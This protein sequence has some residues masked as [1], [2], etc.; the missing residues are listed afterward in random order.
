[1]PA[2][3]PYRDRRGVPVTSDKTSLGDRMKSH[4]RVTRA[5]LP[6]RTYSIL[7]IDGRCFS[8]YLRHANKP[9]DDAVVAAMNAVAEALCSGISG[10]AFAYTQSDE[11]SVLIT[12]FGSEHT[13]PWFGGNIQ[14]IASVAASI[15]TVAFNDAYGRPFGQ[16]RAVF[17]ARTFTLPNAVEVANY[18]LWRQRDCVRNSISMAAQAVFPHK[19]L[20]KVNSDQ[21]QELLWLEHGIN[22]NDYPPGCK[23]GRV[24]V[25]QVGEQ[26]I[27]YTDKRTQLP[28]TT[29]AVRSWWETQ[30]APHFTAEP[31]RWLAAT[32]PAAASFEPPPASR[33]RPVVEV[34]PGLRFGRPAIEG[35]SCN[36]LSERV[37]AGEDPRDVADDYDFTRAQILVACWY[38]AEHQTEPWSAGWKTWAQQAYRH[39]VS[40]DHDKI[41]DPPSKEDT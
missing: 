16:T 14:K 18:M 23:R 13:Q 15:A 3:R 6:P 34:Q 31:G 29:T 24:T 21:M 41:P 37:A 22:W 20:H 32:I 19:R 30:D 28:A 9:F 8:S 12:D 27:S 2:V 33:P 5:V 36:A 38:V 1:M 17:D 4:E 7:R 39:L 25:R 35:V 26:E 10:A 40:G 11:C